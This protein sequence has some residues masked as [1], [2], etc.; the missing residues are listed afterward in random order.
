MKKCSLRR[1]ILHE[2]IEVLF[3]LKFYYIR[4]VY[5][6]GVG[7]KKILVGTR[8]P[9]KPTFWVPAGYINMA[10]FQM[11]IFV[12]QTG[13]TG[14]ETKIISGTGSSIRIRP[15]TRLT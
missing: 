13:K 11:I 2:H 14:T 1:I 7:T 12:Y 5:I 4:L 10:I 15:N 3:H 8:N 6:P 9:L